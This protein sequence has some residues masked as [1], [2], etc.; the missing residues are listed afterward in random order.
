[1]GCGSSSNG[2]VQE[3]GKD[4]KAP[5]EVIAKA[6]QQRRKLSMAPANVGPVVKD[7][8]ADQIVQDADQDTNLSEP[9]LEARG[10][11]RDFLVSRKGVVPYSKGKVNQD[12]G[13]VQ[14]ALGG[15]PRVS[16]FGVMD[17]HGEFGHEVS[18]YIK[19]HLIPKLGEE[20]KLVENVEE[21]MLSATAKMSTQLDNC[22]INTAFSGST[23]VYGVILDRK[24]L[25]VGNVGDSRCVL[26]TADGKGGSIAKGL[27]E[28]QKPENPKEAERIKAAGG[29]VAT[30]PGPA[31]ED[32]GPMRV[33]LAEVDVPGLAMSRSIGDYVSKSVGVISVPEI[34]KH[35]IGPDDEFV[36]WASDG[37][38]EFMS[39]KEAVDIIWKNKDDLKAAANALAD[40][41]IR[42]W[43][44]EEEVV[45]DTTVVVL[46]LKGMGGN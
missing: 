22:Q 25:Y 27:S 17:G 10:P 36:I 40:E 3:P 34:T 13:A 41:A 5:E 39:N 35:E 9:Q 31:D 6:A 11:F 43:K 19:D 30:L 7:G 21:A 16:F 29:R 14:Y 28:D 44:L 20:K 1:M 24:T 32:L 18:Q 42:R 8:E 26:C 45:D 15:N 38:W 12:R 4:E 46:S 37:V 33:W 2:S 23:L